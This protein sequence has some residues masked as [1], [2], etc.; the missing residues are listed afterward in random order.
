MKELLESIHIRHNK[1]RKREGKYFRD[2]TIMLKKNETV[3][4]F[5]L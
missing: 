1:C 3:N 5:T 4:L 2:S